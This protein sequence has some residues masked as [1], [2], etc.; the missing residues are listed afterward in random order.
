MP[1][2]IVRKYVA[3]FHLKNQLV[4][5]GDYS[6]PYEINSDFNKY[7]G[8]TPGQLELTFY[9][10]ADQLYRYPSYSMHTRVVP[11]WKTHAF[12]SL[13]I[14]ITPIELFNYRLIILLCLYY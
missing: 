13:N 3:K 2:S 5:G 7:I 9:S 12:S 14:S 11:V 4:F 6:V 1:S 10:P 8:P